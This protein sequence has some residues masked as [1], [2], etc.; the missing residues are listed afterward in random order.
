MKPAF[1][2]QIP[3]ELQAKLGDTPL[4]GTM[5]KQMED[6]L[7]TLS[8]Q[9]GQW[10]CEDVS[11][12]QKAI[13]AARQTPDEDSRWTLLK[14]CG[15]L[16]GMGTTYGYPLIS[17]MAGSACALLTDARNFTQALPLLEGHV[18][19]ITVLV[20]CEIRS[21]DHPEGQ[22]LANELEAQ[23]RQFLGRILIV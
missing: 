23:V 9:F 22:R 18:A 11:H 13:R 1:I 5:L 16:K 12:L 15:D 6:A 8:G 2:L 4:D 17:R 7:Q 14:C 20:D 3:N 10:L 19:A 21:E